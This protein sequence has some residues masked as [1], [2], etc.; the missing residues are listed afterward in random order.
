MN[1]GFTDIELK[2]LY[3]A[4]EHYI[5]CSNYPQNDVYQRMLLLEKKLEGLCY[6]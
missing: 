1:E 6:S 2:L 5:E 4:V 3:T